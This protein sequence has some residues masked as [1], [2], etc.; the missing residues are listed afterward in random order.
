M[1]EPTLA[2]IED[3]G[4]DAYWQGVEIDPYPDGSPEAEAWDLGWQAA[5][6]EVNG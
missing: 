3:S 2:E 1:R 6:D 4:Y 5:D